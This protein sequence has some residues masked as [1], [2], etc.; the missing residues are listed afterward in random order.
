M[1][2]LIVTAMFPPIRTGTSFHAKNLAQAL[3]AR[4]H[5]VTLATS[6]NI[7]SEDDA[8]PFPVHRLP[9][10]HFPLDNYFKHLRVCAIFPGNF[11]ALAR[12]AK[13]CRAETILLINHYLDIAFPAIYAARCNGIPLVCS[14]G[15]QLQS[16]HPLKH[17]ILNA[18]D[19]LICGKMIFPF[20]DRIVSWDKEISRYLDD[21]HGSKVTGKSVTIN[22]GVNGDPGAFLDHC[23]DYGPH[24]Q[25]LGV[26]AVIEQRDF[27]PLVQ[28]FRPLAQEFPRLRL[29]IIGH[30]YHDAARR[31]AEAHGLAGRV[32]FTGERPHGE[33]LEELGRSDLF[34]S[35]LTGRYIGLGTATIESM[36]MGVPTVANVPADLLGKARLKDM[37][38][39]VLLKDL[40]PEP[41]SEK[42][43][44]LLDNRDLRMR[45]GQGGRAFVSE[46]MSWDRV[47]GD[48]EDLLRSL[49]PAAAT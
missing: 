27:M 42:L 12:I 24:D 47:A 45:I 23:H 3:A 30:V 5:A 19:W 11:P 15:T 1:N 38:D 18:L 37:E 4:G 20:C 33:V 2:I 31:Y 43:R 29:K 25:I 17:R 10:L 14:V 44:S 26:G 34:F 36:L 7:G 48:Y 35:S 46:H 9:A 8:Y 41:I 6:R 39:I 22:Y 32:T 40:S 13:D 16:P 28:A 21:V 49:Q